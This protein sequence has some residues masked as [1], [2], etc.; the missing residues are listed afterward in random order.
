[1]WIRA[2]SDCDWNKGPRLEQPYGA[3][4]S[5]QSPTYE[6]ITRQSALVLCAAAP[7]VQKEKLETHNILVIRTMLMELMCEGLHQGLI[8]TDMPPD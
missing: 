5:V 4:Q 3:V 1:M 6:S 7:K 8:A 2:V